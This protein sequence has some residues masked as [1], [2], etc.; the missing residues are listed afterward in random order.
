MLYVFVLVTLLSVDTV[1][2]RTLGDSL[3]MG[4]L[5]NL[6]DQIGDELI[7]HDGLRNQ[8]INRGGIINMAHDDDTDDMVRD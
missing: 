6:I 8:E 7:S 3:S 2:G 4:D 1:L 5:E